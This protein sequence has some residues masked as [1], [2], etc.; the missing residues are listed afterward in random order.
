MR[1]FVLLPAIAVLALTNCDGDTPVDIFDISGGVSGTVRTASGA[2]VAGAVVTGSASYPLGDTG[3]PISD[4]TQT[5][6]DGHYALR[7]TTLNLADADAP[8]ALQVRPPVTSG[9]LGLDTSGF[10][11]PIARSSPNP[12]Q[13]DMALTPYQPTAEHLIGEFS[14][15]A[16]ADFE[17]YDLFLAVDEV[18]DSVRGVWSLAFVTS[19][20]THD[21]QF[22]GSLQ[23]SELRLRL[24]PDEIYEATFDVVAHVLPGDTLI[25]GDLSLV[26]SGTDPLCFTIFD[27]FTLRFGD[28]SG[29]PIGR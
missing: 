4:S 7:F 16:G 5:S 9:L 25:A 1:A 11:V 29:L 23:G 22:S 17:A 28:V 18:T 12:V 27:P 2:P 19:C 20:S 14:G 21:G 8:V 6:A 15:R 24:R 10:T 13:V 3:M 26:Q